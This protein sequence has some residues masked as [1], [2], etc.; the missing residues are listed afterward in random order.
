MNIEFRIPIAPTLGFFGQVEFFNFCLR[1][2]GGIYTEAKIN[3]YVGE[4]FK[5]GEAI[6]QNSWSNDYNVE[7]K[8][9]PEQIFNKYDMYGTAN[10]RYNDKTEAKVVIQSDADTVLVRDIDDVIR[11]IDI[12]FPAIAGHNAH[13]PPETKGTILPESTSD[14]YWPEIFRIFNIEWP[15]E[16][17]QY[18]MDAEGLLPKIPPY[19]N[20][21]FVAMNPLALEILGRKIDEVH[22]RLTS[23]TESFMRC[24]IGL[25]LVSQREKFKIITL[26]AEYNMSNDS[27]HQKLN[28]KK[29]E[30]FRVIHYLRTA[31]LDRSK[32]YDPDY[33]NGLSDTMN[34]DANSVIVPLLKEWHYQR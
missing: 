12:P 1:R 3:V 29:R 20:L 27:T 24:Q 14:R 21:G 25:T 11:Q 18:S 4:N 34:N 2:L 7:W 32:I 28:H 33:V 13:S 9:V 5:I 19:F 26:G 31:E 16:L 23:V 6:K 17:H 30:D 15:K 8:A 22:E 10:W